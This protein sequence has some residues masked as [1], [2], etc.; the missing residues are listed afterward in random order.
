MKERRK[1]GRTKGKRKDIRKE[2]RM[3]GDKDVLI[4]H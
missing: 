2:S 4:R 3:E 1:G